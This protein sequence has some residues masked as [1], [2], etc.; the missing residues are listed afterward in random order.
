MNNANA[1]ALKIFGEELRFKTAS[2][3]VV[4]RGIVEPDTNIE[5]LEQVQINHQSLLIYIDETQLK[6]KGVERRQEVV[7]RGMTYSINEI[8]NDMNGMAVFRVSRT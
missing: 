3:T 2:R 7:V 5:H 4:L 8:G 1:A 6:N